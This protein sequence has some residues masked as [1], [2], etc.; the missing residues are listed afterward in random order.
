MEE[1]ARTPPAGGTIVKM[2]DMAGRLNISKR[3]IRRRVTAILE[4]RKPY[5][6]RWK[7]IRDYQ[8][9]FSGCFDD[10]DEEENAAQRK[11][12]SIYNSSTW[13][14]NLVF[15]SGVM[16]GLTPPSR[17]WFRLGFS[18]RE[19]TDNSDVGKLLDARMDIMNEVLEKSNFYTA[20]HSCYLELAYGQAPIGIFPDTRYGVHFKAYPV[21]SYAY[22]CD[23]DGSVTTFIHRMKMS[24]HQLVEK[25]G[26][27]NVP[28]NVKH[29]IEKSGGY[30]AT[31][32]VVWYVAPNRQARPEEIGRF[33][34][35]YISVY[36]LEESSDEELLYIGGFDEWPVPV[37]RYMIN[38]QDAYG[39][40]PGWY[41][42][43]DSKA[44]HLAEKDLLT[45]IELQVKPPMQA[46][47]DSALKGIHLMPSGKT[48]VQQ[49]GNV[50]PLFQVQVDLKDLREQIVTYE[51]RI[52]ETYSANL[53]M[54]LSSMEDKTMTARE[55][56]ERN[57]EKM[58]MLG[59]V[60]QRMQY[61]FL[62]KIIERVYMILD[63]AQIF[64]QPE[65]EETL[66]ALRGEDIK[67]E[68]ISPLAQAQKMGG[69]TTIE[70]LFAFVMQAAQGE[71]S[72]KGKLDFKEM[73][74]R[75]ADMLGAPQSVLRTDKEF[76]AM[77][78]E[79][80]ARAAQ[81]EELAQAQQVA[82]MAAPVAQA[83]KNATE[84]AKDGNPALRQML[85][86]DPPGYGKV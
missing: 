33:Y 81:Q 74:N 46:T 64:P 30:K 15:A 27:E 78:E 75:Y 13:M 29:E 60:V 43:G 16:S 22:E 79:A 32:R 45:A 36:Y 54:M 72:I 57:Q 69:I 70:Q 34:K 11:D 58:T 77:L 53:F 65:D 8:L 12:K 48:Y 23:A 83:A 71:E 82:Q 37:A 14:A 73:V 19:L 55:V 56:I 59:P 86:V 9:P 76:E 80:Q 25:F 6:I 18:N 2:S 42:E 3:D 84:A 17:K 67:I 62:S 24:A 41:A 39:K 44:L 21:G 20:I 31:H 4:K 63:R 38:G 52:K 47:A 5:E 40:G 51:G 50:V 35:P 1:K 85:G 7:N 26:E 28:E 49:I 66:A 10:I 68:Y 61:E